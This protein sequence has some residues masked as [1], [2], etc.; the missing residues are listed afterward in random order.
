MVRQIL[1]G[2]KYFKEK[3]N[4]TPHVAINFDSFGTVAV[5]FKFWQK[6]DIKDICICALRP[7][8]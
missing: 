4:K 7:V 2:R 8:Y 6:A 1:S 5:L 3:F